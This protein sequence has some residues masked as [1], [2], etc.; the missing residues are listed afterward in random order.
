MKKAPP[1]YTDDRPSK[2]QMKQAMDD[3]QALGSKLVELSKGQLK[4]LMLPENLHNAILDYQRFPKH[5][6]R[7]RQ[8]QYIGKVM[9]TL[10]A[11]PIE[12]GLAALRGESAAE[13]AHMHRMED[14][15]NRFLAD[16]KV[17]EEILGLWPQ[18]DVSYL[19]QL[20]RNALK[21]Q[22]QNKPPKSFRLIFKTFKSLEKGEQT[23]ADTDAQEFETDDE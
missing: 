2:T 14:L 3:L 19:R 8:L 13:I 11:E 9:R 17:V 20:R 12:A 4:S 22:L 18:A 16:E 1:E 23:G 6:A 7:R 5:E 10:D 21:E 15:R